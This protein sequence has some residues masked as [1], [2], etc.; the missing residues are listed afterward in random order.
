MKE[1]KISNLEKLYAQ[2][3]DIN[4]LS[5]F[6]KMKLQ[7][8]KELYLNKN[9]LKEI[10][11]NAVTK[12]PNLERISFNFNSIS[13][14]HNINQIMD[15]KNLKKFSIENN[16]LDSETKKILKDIEK[17]IKILKILV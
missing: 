2:N 3:N 14:I 13:K 9:E 16:R 6:D 7:K 8:L 5:L 4:S 15:L 17:E 1:F 12:F 11:I 10:D